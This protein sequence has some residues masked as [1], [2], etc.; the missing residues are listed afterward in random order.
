MR[1]RAGSTVRG[2]GV[3][4]GAAVAVAGA[5]APAR[6]AGS[7]G[8]RRR[9][10]AVVAAAALLAAAGCVLVLLSA[11]PTLGF[12][13][14][15]LSNFQSEYACDNSTVRIVRPRTV[16]D[17]R[18]AV[19]A[20]ERVMAVGG[21][22]SWNQRFFCA[23]NGTAPASGDGFNASAP[24]AAASSPLPAAGGVA[25]IV[26]GTVRP[27][28][29]EVNE[30]DETVLVDAGVRTIDLLRFLA[31]YVTPTAPSGWTL[32][33]FPW[34]VFQTLGGAVSTGTHGSSLEHKSL[35]SQAV[36]LHVVLANG[37]HVEL[38]DASHPFLMRALRLSVGKLGII[39]HIRFR[40]VREMP[41]TRTLHALRASAFRSLMAEVQA[42]WAAAADT[43]GN[44]ALPDWLRGHGDSEW[45]WVPQRHEFL[46][47]TYTR[48]DVA[49]AAERLKVL[50]AY[51][52]N[53][54]ADVTTAYNT[55]LALL[56][57]AAAERA[58]GKGPAFS[59]DDFPLLSNVTFDPASGNVSTA[60]LP[61]LQKLNDTVINAPW[62]QLAAA[63][64]AT[65]AGGSAAAASALG[66][67]PAAPAAGAAAA[68]SKAAAAAPS[69]AAQAGPA[70]AAGA[71][72]SGDQQ[73][74]SLFSATG[75]A[76]NI[77]RPPRRAGGRIA[78][79]G[80]SN[81]SSISGGA[82][83]RN[84]ATSGL[85]AAAVATDGQ[86]AVYG[87]GWSIPE[88]GTPTV[89]YGLT[90]M[91]DAYIDIS[92][93]GVYSIAA[94]TTRE[95]LASYL[96]QPEAILDV[97]IRRVSFDQYEVAM[98]ITSVG[99]CWS[100][101]LDLLYGHDNIDGDNPAYNGSASVHSLPARLNA[102]QA[103]A[104]A[105]NGS[106]AA[107]YFAANGRPDY[108]F[109]SNPLI[110]MTGVEA[111]LL[112]NTYDIPHFWLNIEDYLYYNRLTRR[113]NDVFKAV[114]SY[115]RSD[116]RCGSG[117][118]SGGG[119]RLHWGKSGWPDTGC[120]HGDREYPGTWCDF[121]CAVRE[122]DPTGRFTD[123]TGGTGTDGALWNWRGVDLGR[124]CVP[125]VGFNMS[126]AGCECRVTH[127]RNASTCPPPPYY[128]YR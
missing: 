100:G 78:A 72:G 7:G 62:Q 13:P 118:L 67:L 34:F 28:I 80:S 37:S 51:A 69:V 42:A 38:S 88:R 18:A 125:G 83:A 46:A 97:N 12:V 91:A 24:A 23:S 126:L 107:S 20:H 105:A 39:T 41:V 104:A 31:A 56:E 119:A 61:V 96:Y 6:V 40:I 94:N 99:D 98:P 81:S 106:A 95:A 59:I 120:W 70:E 93:S 75:D 114:M 27:L 76:L 92:R 44:G 35:S 5:V 30:T 22:W 102:S 25:N 103:A 2:G 47:V 79:L 116:P 123:S 45:F 8:G 55:S 36:G 121:G 29:I 108:G 127:A 124:C 50:S 112:S 16:A 43:A 110:R 48:G 4:A 60:A 77:L 19:V 82:A 3:V 117:G 90:G 15:D 73:A 101:L 111:A 74:V 52:R 32:P 53:G 68:S 9:L 63:A 122:L 14:I 113:S 26:M 57:A 54:G 49:D 64:A 128:T 87:T 89:F 1:R 10:S 86:G 85:I 21:G 33:A 84:N 65:T 11:P 66:L 71:A 58:A 109:R 17:I 115:L